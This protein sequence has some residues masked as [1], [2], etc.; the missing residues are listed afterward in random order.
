[1]GRG[2]GRIDFR[3]FLLAADEFSTSL[4]AASQMLCC[5]P[6]ISSSFYTTISLAHLD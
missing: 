5:L 4:F 1:M 2:N 6:K 3:G